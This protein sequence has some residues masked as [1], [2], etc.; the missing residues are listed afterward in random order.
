M[1]SLKKKHQE[2]LELLAEFKFLT[3]SQFVTLGLY[4]N[5][6]DTTN[7]LK[8]WAKSIGKLIMGFEP[9]I[10]RI[11]D[12]YYLK[13][14]GKRLLIETLICE[15]DTIKIPKKSSSVAQKNYFHTKQMINFHI[16]LSTWL[17]QNDGTKVFLTYDFDQMGTN[18]SLTKKYNKSI[19]TINMDDKSFVP[20]II[21]QFNISS[22]DYLFLFEQHNGNDTKRLHLQLKVHLKALT[23]PVVREKYDFKK[24]H[25]VAI[26]CEKKSVKESILI[27]LKE[28]VEFTNFHKFFIFKTIEELQDDFFNKWTKIDGTKVQFT[29]F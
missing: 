21:T 23:T 26:V 8:Q 24:S 27:R 22:Q 1:I 4:K 16:G 18:S 6:G 19:N 17:K 14:Y 28:D 29:S 13:P 10:G 11:E 2:A 5:R 3:S 12:I 25:R 20:D 15:E 7:A 9:G